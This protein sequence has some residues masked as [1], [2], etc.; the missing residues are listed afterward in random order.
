MDNIITF[1]TLYS[2]DGS[3]RIRTFHM[4]L[5][6]NEYRTVTG[7]KDG[8]KTES[9]WTEAIATNVGRSNERLSCAQAEFE[10]EAE[11]KKKLKRGYFKSEAEVDTGISTFPMLA[12]KYKDLKKPIDFSEDVWAQLKFDGIRCLT[13]EVT[14]MT[15]RKAEPIVTF[16][17]ILQR[18]ERIWKDYN[19]KLD[20]ELYGHQYAE[21]LMKI[22]SIV[23]P[24]TVTDERLAEARTLK[25][26]V[27]DIIAIDDP[28]ML[29]KDRIALR[30]E[31]FAKFF[32]DDEF[33]VN[34]ETPLITDQG[35]LDA[36]YDTARHL[37]FEGQIIRLNRVYQEKKRSAGLLKR[38]EYE[39]KEFPIVRIEPGTGNWAGAAK[40]VVCRDPENDNKEFA[41]GLT[42]TYGDNV[43]IL[44]EADEYIDGEATM[45]FFKY[46]IYG[47]P[48]QGTVQALYKGKRDV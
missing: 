10:I 27:Y 20:G 24:K 31:I 47:V 2:R 25:Y 34:V 17:H 46:S 19:V 40:S 18:V 3:G 44:E 32:L 45:R 29:Q 14:E 41:G 8:G 22:N 1:D 21:N 13:T 30:N 4:E 11:Y 37:S 43:K 48:V 9:G 6:G 35:Q 36:H 5:N 39:D 33:L 38:K 23:R 26:Y 15:T 7:L 16:P 28:L 42:G 12:N